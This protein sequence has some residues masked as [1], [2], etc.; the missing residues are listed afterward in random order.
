MP[1][2]I[3]AAHPAFLKRPPEIPS[4]RGI[5][6]EICEPC[7]R[8]S[9]W[10]DSGVACTP[11]RYSVFPVRMHSVLAVDDPTVSAPEPPRGGK[12]GKRIPATATT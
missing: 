7:Y 11:L 4:M 10:I 3:A 8:V 5:V 9:L 12:G 6:T 2:L 1:F